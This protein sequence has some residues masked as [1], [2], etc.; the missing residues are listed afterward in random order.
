LDNNT[1]SGSIQFN[2]NTDF[3]IY[4][5][6]HTSLVIDTYAGNADFTGTVVGSF[7]NGLQIGTSIAD[8]LTLTASVT[9]TPVPIPGSLFLLVSGL[10][11]LVI[12]RK[13][14]KS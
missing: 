4:Y 2:A 10:G 14:A 9:Q 12:R 1:L 6:L 8:P 5:V 13:M 3:D 7:P 11:G